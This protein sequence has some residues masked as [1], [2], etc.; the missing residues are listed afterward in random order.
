[1]KMAKCAQY[2]KWAGQGMYINI[3]YEQNENMNLK[4]CFYVQ[5]KKLQEGNGIRIV[6]VENKIKALFLSSLKYWQL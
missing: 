3:A 4:K 2:K 5:Q 6:E 1:M